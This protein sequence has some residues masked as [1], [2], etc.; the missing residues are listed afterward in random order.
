MPARVALVDHASEAPV[1]RDLLEVDV[2]DIELL[3]ERLA[4]RLV[5]DVVELEEHLAQGQLELRLLSEGVLE[6]GFADG[7][8]LPEDL[9]EPPRPLEA[10]RVGSLAWRA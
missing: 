8:E 6:L 4:H 7:P 5:G 10:V 3:G 9:A 2:R 1:E